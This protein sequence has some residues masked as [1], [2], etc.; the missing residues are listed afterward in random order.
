MGKGGLTLSRDASALVHR[1]AWPGNIGELQN[2]IERS[3][4]TSKGTLITARL[5]RYQIDVTPD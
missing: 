3:L 2:A 1:H 4:I 5:K